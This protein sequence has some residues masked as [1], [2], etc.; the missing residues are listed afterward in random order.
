MGTLLLLAVIK[1]AHAAVR[2]DLMVKLKN[3]VELQ[4]SNVFS[5]NSL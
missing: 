3:F 4:K 1:V 5:D 2:K